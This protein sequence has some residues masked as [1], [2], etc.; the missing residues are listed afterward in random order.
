MRHSP[1]YNEIFYK[2]ET[3]YEKGCGSLNVLWKI[4]DISL[5]EVVVGVVVT[6]IILL[7]CILK[8]EKTSIPI[9]Y[10]Y[11]PY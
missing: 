6:E 11:A 5:T 2:L 10:N 1:E 8:T 3:E 7:V 4:L 9:L